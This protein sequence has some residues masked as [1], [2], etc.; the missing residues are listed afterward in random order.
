MFSFF[1]EIFHLALKF[2]TY[3]KKKTKIHPKY[4]SHFS[5][6]I[7]NSIFIPSPKHASS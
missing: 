1:L 4:P 2:S 5:D 3:D 6:I 7:S